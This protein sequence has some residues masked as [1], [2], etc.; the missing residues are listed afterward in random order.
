MAK[1]LLYR[2][3]DDSGFAPNPFWGYLTLAT[4]TPNHQRASLRVG[5]WILGVESKSLSQ[6]RKEKGCNVKINT[7]LIFVAKVNEIL[8]LNQYFKDHRFADKK[9]VNDPEDWLKRRGDNNYYIEDGKWKWIRGHDHEP[10]KLRNEPDEK[11]F[12]YRKDFEKLW[13]DE[14]MRK[15][16]GDILKDIRGDRV[17][18]SSE[19]IY[20]G[21]SGI[22]FSPDFI[23][24]LP[25]ARGIKYCPEYRKN[26][27]K[28]Y[29][30]SLFEK[31]RKGVIGNP[32][33][34]CINRNE[35]NI[36]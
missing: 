23:D 26:D 36:Q 8:S 32:I 24:I 19:F 28:A 34:C 31:F 21:D 25:R 1:I 20:F 18:I 12:F 5:D 13:K 6:K 15:K 14:S 4:C 30:H 16:Y 29:I 2:L 22:E 27:F 10:K 17:F 33:N 35:C 9:H 11:V 7:S 3:T